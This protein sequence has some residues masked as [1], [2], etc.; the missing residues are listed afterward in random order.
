M[1][2][3]AHRC[4]RGDEEGFHLLMPSLGKDKRSNICT[5]FGPG[6][7]DWV[8]QGGLSRAIPLQSENLMVP[9]CNK[10]ELVNEKPVDYLVDYLLADLCKIEEDEKSPRHF[11]N[12]ALKVA[13][14]VVLCH[15]FCPCGR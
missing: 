8:G 10:L 4:S 9:T 1:W 7:R 12:E 6:S 13:G 15:L 3:S 5:T 11:S 14:H 2:R